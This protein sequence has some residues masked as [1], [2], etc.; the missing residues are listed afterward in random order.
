MVHIGQMSWALGSKCVW[1]W[2]G[3]PVW[4][5]PKCP[6]LYL[7]LDVTMMFH[8]VPLGVEITSRGQ[9]QPLW[10]LALGPNTVYSSVKYKIYI[11][12][13]IKGLCCISPGLSMVNHDPRSFSYWP[14]QSYNVLM[15]SLKL[16]ILLIMCSFTFCVRCTNQTKVYVVTYL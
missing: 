10:T 16:I 3:W 8:K 11:L 12:N 5:R 6:K 1:R 13:I 14:Q 7:C 4:L 15:M 2:F 9:C